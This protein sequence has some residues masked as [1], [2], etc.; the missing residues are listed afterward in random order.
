MKSKDEIESISL[1]KYIS[2][3]IIYK[4]TN[5]IQIL[6]FHDYYW[7]NFFWATVTRCFRTSL[8][9]DQRLENWYTF[10]SCLALSIGDKGKRAKAAKTRVVSGVAKG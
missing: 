1:L 2:G 6:V 10:V 3:I 8:F 9:T 5:E 7:Q 4:G